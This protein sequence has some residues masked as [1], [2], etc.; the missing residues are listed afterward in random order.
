VLFLF[1]KIIMNKEELFKKRGNITKYIV[2]ISDMKCNPCSDEF[3]FKVGDLL[4]KEV[5]MFNEHLEVVSVHENKYFG[6]TFYFVQ[7]NNYT[8]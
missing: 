5:E 3:N 6:I 1:K 4:N 2:N 8:L 7:F